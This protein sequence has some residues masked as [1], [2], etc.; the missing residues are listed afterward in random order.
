MSALIMANVTNR[1]WRTLVKQR[2]KTAIFR[3]YLIV[4]GKDITKEYRDELEFLKWK[5]TYET[6]MRSPQNGIEHVRSETIYR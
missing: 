5:S 3:I 4:R 1:T 2:R 6:A